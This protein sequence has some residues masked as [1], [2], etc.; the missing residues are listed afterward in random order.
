MKILKLLSSKYLLFL[1][2]FLAIAIYV[3]VTYVQKNQ[4]IRKKAA[5]V[6]RQVEMH[7]EPSGGTY[8]ANQALNI[9]LT[10]DMQFQPV[11]GIQFVAH[12]TGYPAGYM[13][14]VPAQ[15][16]G[17][18]L[19]LNKIPNPEGV[20]I[21][22]AY[23]SQE[24]NQP[25]RQF[26]TVDL[27]TLSLTASYSGTLNISV[28]PA[29]SK[30]IQNGTSIDILE[31]PKNASF[32]F[33]QPTPTSYPTRYP[34]VYPTTLPTSYQTP[35]PTPY[36]T[37]YQTPYPTSYQTPYPTS[38]QTPYPT[39]YQTPYP[40]PT[41]TPIVCKRQMP[42][43]SLSP[44]SWRTN[45]GSTASFE[46]SLQNMDS[47]EC[48]ASTFSMVIRNPWT[49]ETKNQSFLLFPKDSFKN[50]TS[51]EI[52]YT[53]LSNTT[54]VPINFMHPNLTTIGYTRPVEV[55][56]PTPYQFEMALRLEGVSGNEATGAKTTIRFINSGINLV[57]PPMSL[58]HVGTNIYKVGFQVSPRQLPPGK[59]YTMIVKPE[60][61]IAKKYCKQTGQT[62]PCSSGDSF[63]LPKPV[64]GSSLGFTLMGFPI[65]PGDL[66]PQDNKADLSDFDKI[67]ALL[68]KPCSSL[69][70]QEKLIG[71][72]DYSGCINIRDAF[73]MRKAL[74]TRYDEN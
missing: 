58:V 28:D 37:S 66:Y 32:S 72:L 10:A 63:D 9:K 52:P 73:L 15:I 27:G 35:Y 70:D 61:H 18:R 68:S 33:V 65:E 29:L 39:S 46:Y 50:T 57:T 17:M 23:I 13:D 34:T 2:L 54:E 7:F 38:Y 24:P 20:D 8:P 22:L 11:D 69:T 64:A 26:T 62:G 44:Q 14:F 53:A 1:S 30:V 41:P 3:G 59:G 48:G 43:I 12:I 49:N 45:A 25:F 40:T 74:E 71:D 67:R 51:V 21:E 47:Y 16:P 42:T 5:V 36:P 6:T 4:E 56:D 19:I 31:I 60:K 55:T